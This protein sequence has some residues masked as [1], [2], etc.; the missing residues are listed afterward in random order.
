[1]RRA[2]GIRVVGLLSW[3]IRCEV[4]GSGCINSATGRR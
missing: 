3:I 1:M 2:M 4:G